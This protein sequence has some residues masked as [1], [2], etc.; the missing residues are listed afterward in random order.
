MSND[1]Q[2]G[3]LFLNQS[4]DVVQAELHNHWFL[5][6]LSLPTISHAFQPFL[7][8]R[9]TLRFVLLEQLEKVGSSG[10]VESLSELV[11]AGRH[12]QPLV[13]SF[14]LTLEAHILGPLHKPPEI[15]LWLDI[16]ANTEV[17]WALLD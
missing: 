9:R 17:L 7:L 10:F 16:T 13:Q 11:D 12:L 5:A 8:L 6:E 15:S 3:L 4:S 2:L 14:L 1:H